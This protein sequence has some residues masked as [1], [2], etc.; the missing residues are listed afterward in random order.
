MADGLFDLAKRFIPAPARFYTQTMLG[1][2]TK[3]LTQN[4]L[5]P[6]ELSQLN[7]AIQ[8]SRIRL[9]QKYETIKN[10]KSFNELP[11]DIQKKITASEDYLK[12][13]IGGKTPEEANLKGK[14]LSDF[15]ANALQEAKTKAILN[16]EQFQQGL[17]NVQ[18]QDYSENNPI[19]D[20]LGRFNYK[21][22]PDGTI[23]ILDSYDFSNPQRQQNVV[24]YAKMTPTE[25]ALSVAKSG[26]LNI[27]LPN[28]IKGVAGKAG[29]AYIGADGRPVNIT[30]NPNML[31]QQNSTFE[32]QPM[33]T[34]PFGNT[35]GSSIR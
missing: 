32:Q 13:D 19:R 28:Y 7:E 11:M 21:I 5:T 12:F 26:F 3:P 30:Y 33:Y 6:E 1:D 29:E 4:D 23:N 24:D 25:K 22:N 17:G 8:S 20:T 16:Q 9:Q 14:N 35:I 2:K 27:G 18:Y 15:L 34:D 10:A 31:P